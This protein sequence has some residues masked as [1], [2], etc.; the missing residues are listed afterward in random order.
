MFRARFLPVLVLTQVAGCVLALAEQP[1]RIPDKRIS[2]AQTFTLK[3][4]IHP[5]VSAARDLGEVDPDRALSHI[6]IHFQP[7]AAQEAD[8]NQLLKNLQN[9]TSSQ[10]HKFLTPAQYTERFGLSTSDMNKVVAWL[11][12]KGFTDVQPSPMRTSVSMSANAAAAENAFQIS[13]HR[14][15]VNGKEHFANVN[16]PV[17]PKA[18]QGMVS[19]VRGLNDFHPRP[20]AVRPHFTSSISGDHFVT[21]DDFATIYD[22]H[23]LYNSGINGS[24]ISIAIAGQTDIALS[25]IEA[26][27][28]AAGLPANDPTVVLDGTDPGTSNDD[29]SEAEL[30]LELAGAVAPNATVV[31]VNSSDVFTSMQYAIDNDL[32]PVVSVS[33][34]YCE[35]QSTEAIATLE[36]EF[37]KA[38]ALGITILSASGDDGAADCDGGTDSNPPTIATQGLAVDY[39]ASSPEVTGVGGTEFTD[40]NT[41]YATQYWSDTNNSSNGSALSYI[42]ETTWNDTSSVG[43]FSAGGGGASAS[44]TK[45]S[46]QTGPGVPSDNARDVPD[47]SLTAS[48][49]VDPVLICDTGWCTNGFR[50][51]QS[52][53]DT[54]GGTSIGAPSMAGIVALIVQK[55]GGPQGNINPILYQLAAQ[56]SG[57]FHDITTGNNIVA[58]QANTPDCNATSLT[59][60][61]SAGTGYDQATGL[62]SIDGANL[63]N[64]WP[65][66]YIALNAT[67]LTIPSGTTSGT[68][69]VTV[70]RTPHYNNAVTFTCS[71]SSSL[72]T[73]TP[74]T[75]LTDSGTATLTIARASSSSAWSPLPFPWQWPAGLLVIAA[76]TLLATRRRRE[77]LWCGATGLLIAVAGCGGGSSVS[78][79]VATT[80]TP[81]STPQTATVTLT[82]TSGNLPESF[83]ITVTVD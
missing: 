61:Y 71:T 69:A 30:D 51:S 20:H 11:Q 67:S 15:Q 28:S 46:W 60:G 36:P 40:G 63:V 19:G 18:L 6:T 35:P 29:L 55:S 22:L 59:L 5:L 57:L 4:N 31:Y 81:T 25:D 83:A 44:F 66:F 12:S 43:S 7:T 52:Y 24:G 54:V 23:S 53:L 74:P 49:V 80:P 47:V 73:C 62:G 26:F 37:K 27:R 38:N 56:T 79:T 72:V 45:P 70:T 2:E 32:A 50:N 78:Q 64:G 58:C 21:P 14:Y 34:G 68:V 82:A 48:T 8:L 10:Y 65:D 33:Y 1:S 17:L 9:R 3:G 42:P 76:A 41:T 77:L 39:P 13:M 75:S 16:D